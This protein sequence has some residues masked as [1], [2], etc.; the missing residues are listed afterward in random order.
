MANST[1]IITDLKSVQTN[2]PSTATLNNAI[3]PSGAIQDYNGNVKLLILKSQEI[4]VLIAKVLAA[5]DPGSDATNLS[6]IQKV[7]NDFV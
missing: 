5:T 2:G 1:Q 7:S 6:L 4:S 3:A